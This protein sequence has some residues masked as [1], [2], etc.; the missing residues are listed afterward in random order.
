MPAV[1]PAACIEIDRDGSIRGPY[2]LTPCP[3][4]HKP[5]CL[6]EAAAGPLVILLH[7]CPSCF[8]EEEA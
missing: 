1:E 8:Y 3:E 4:C 5:L 7:V 6:M 2:L